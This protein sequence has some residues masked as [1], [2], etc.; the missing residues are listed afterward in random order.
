MGTNNE[1]SQETV[2]SMVVRIDGGT[3]FK[4]E[5]TSFEITDGLIKVTALDGLGGPTQ[6]KQFFSL[7]VAA[8]AG[9]YDFNDLRETKY[10]LYSDMYDV[11]YE[12]RY[13]AGAVL[14]DETARQVYA[15]FSLEMRLL[16]KSPQDVI[17]PERVTLQTY[18]AFVAD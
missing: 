13:G 9:H 11:S 1:A 7:A 12:P 15:V 6:G 5:R 4:V 16:S 17:A 14:Y 8:R 2:G 18:F 10:H 3:D